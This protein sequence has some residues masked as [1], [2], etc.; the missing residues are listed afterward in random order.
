MHCMRPPCPY[1]I[2][3]AGTR[4]M[5]ALCGELRLARSRGAAAC[6]CCML[7][8]CV[9]SRA[10]HSHTRYAM[11]VRIYGRLNGHPHLFALKCSQLSLRT[12]S[13]MY[14]YWLLVK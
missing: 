1:S 4:K 2:A 14:L 13:L 3:C 9:G 8:A 10:A 5:L 12:V 6:N 7:P 11:G